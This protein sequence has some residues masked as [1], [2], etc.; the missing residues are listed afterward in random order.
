M[1]E[2]VQKFDQWL[3]VNGYSKNTRRDYTQRI[4]NLLQAVQD[5]I[6]QEKIDGYFLAIK[7]KFKSKTINCYRDAF[8]A[9]F[10]FKNLEIKIPKRFKEERMIPDTITFK[11]FEEKVIGIIRKTFQFPEKPIA[12]LDLMLK[13][14]LRKSE[15]CA[16]K[17][18]DIDLEK[19]TGKVFRQKCNDWH[20]FLFDSVTQRRLTAYFSREDEGKNAFNIG[21]GG[22]NHIFS[23]LKEYFPNQK[24]SPHV[25]R[26]SL[27]TKLLE[28]GVNLRYIQTILGH[29]SISSTERYTKV[30][31]ESLQKKYLEVMRHKTRKVEKSDSRN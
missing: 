4:E 23:R 25:L 10:K 31:V 20:I 13:S 11:D 6:D 5:N 7:Q 29:R 17:R 18:G 8:G 26:H 22:I 9:F 28:E 14:G 21:R 2:E 24:F 19:M 12:I 30:N 3:E 15:I 1:I 16:L 27:A